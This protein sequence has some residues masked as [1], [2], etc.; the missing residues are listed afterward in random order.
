MDANPEHWRGYVAAGAEERLMRLYGLSDRVRYYWPQGEVQAA[1]GRLIANVDAARVAPASSLSSPGRCCSS[2][3]SR[4][5]RRASSPQSRR[6]RR[7]IP[8]RRRRDDLTRRSLDAARLSRRIP[9]AA[10]VSS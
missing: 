9:F 4:H 10:G 6:R 8:S 3:A 1:L 5:C 7:Q 2:A